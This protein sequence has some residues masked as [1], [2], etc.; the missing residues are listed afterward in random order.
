MCANCFVQHTLAN[1]TPSCPVCRG[2][3]LSLAD[4]VASNDHVLWRCRA[5]NVPGITY[6]S[7]IDDWVLLNRVDVLTQQVRSSVRNGDVDALIECGR[8]GLIQYDTFASLVDQ[9]CDTVPCVPHT[10]C[11]MM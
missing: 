4:V 3:M 9:L 5:R 7:N 2:P 8:L 1:H 6:P 11:L 10:L